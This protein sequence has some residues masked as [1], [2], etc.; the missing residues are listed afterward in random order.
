MDYSKL[1]KAQLISI[2]M[3]LQNYIQSKDDLSYEYTNS[4]IMEVFKHE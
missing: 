3:Y 1:D 2:I 4:R